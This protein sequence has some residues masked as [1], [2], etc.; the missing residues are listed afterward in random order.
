MEKILVEI[1]NISKKYN[2]FEAIKN[3]NLTINQGEFVTLLGPSGCGKS[4]LLKMLGGFENSTFGKILVNKIDIK[5]L[6]IQRRPTV[7]VFQDYSLFPNLTAY[8]NI[9]YGLHMIREPLTNVQKKTKDNIKN[10]INGANKKAQLKI[11]EILK[12]QNLL[13]IENNKLELS[14]QKK[15][16]LEKIHSFTEEEYDLKI[17]SIKNI[18]QKKFKKNIYKSIPLKIK[19]IEI[20][21]NLLMNLNFN[22]AIKYKFYG[23]EISDEVINNSSEEFQLI[24]KLLSYEIAY[25]ET[26]FFERKININREKYNDLDYWIS[27]WQNFADE[28]REWYE[29]KVLTRKL[30]KNEQ[31]KKIMNVIKLVG[32]EGSEEKYPHQ[33]S[34]GMQQRVAL[35]RAIIVEPKILLLDEPLSAL[36]AKVRKQM[37]KELKRLH[38]ELGITFILVTHDQEE[39][40]TLSDK[41]VVMSQGEI[42]QIGTPQDVYDRPKNTWVANFI[43]QANIFEAKMLK[44]CQVELNNQ[45]FKVSDHYKNITPGKS[46]KFM[47][48][49][50]DFDVVDPSKKMISVRMIDT[51]YKGLLWESKCLWNNEKIN[52]ESI[53]KIKSGDL[54][55]LAFDYEDI[56]LMED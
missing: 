54:T 19:L 34:G 32:L 16:L 40:L 23:S 47:I 7:T 10:V 13:N 41:I 3:F 28:E 35:A 42:E 11:K 51:L 30:T 22:K 39:A 4:T 1:K 37:Q 6:P 31:H 12:K 36:D 33:L 2:D 52:I 8:K 38:K 25:R 18:F 55:H 46:V 50:E 45:I 15:P 26:H 14:I 56:H 48:R 44:N 17:D 43:G 27:Y 49:P 5:D 9:K 24:K 53:D 20:L 29:K 21:N